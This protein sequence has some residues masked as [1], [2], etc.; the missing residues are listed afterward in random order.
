M[1]AWNSNS[2][3]KLVRFCFLLWHQESEF[4]RWRNETAEPTLLP[5]PA[6]MCQL[7][8]SLFRILRLLLGGKKKNRAHKA[9]WFHNVQ[10]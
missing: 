1:R 4:L 9:R 2:T 8:L 5:L 6:P 3:S 7:Q 10:C